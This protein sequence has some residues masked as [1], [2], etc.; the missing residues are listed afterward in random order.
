MRSSLKKITFQ[1]TRSLSVTQTHLQSDQKNWNTHFNGWQTVLFRAITNKEGTDLKNLIAASEAHK[2]EIDA[3]NQINNENLTK[4]AALT[5]KAEESAQKNEQNLLKISEISKIL[6][7][8]EEKI[9]SGAA[10]LAAKELELVELAKSQQNALQVHLKEKEEHDLLKNNHEASLTE[11]TSIKTQLE[12]TL[13]LLSDKENEISIL[14]KSIEEAKL[15]NESALEAAVGKIAAL[16]S[17][18]E[19]KSA[20]ILAINE[21]YEN[22]VAELKARIEELSVVEEVLVVGWGWREI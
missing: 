16:E 7:I 2:T 9:V 15:A 6:E 8:S 5:K 21:K 3:A 12:T 10:V 17:E 18:S 19:G 14:N 22:S 11:L 20:E 4:I 13:K 1:A